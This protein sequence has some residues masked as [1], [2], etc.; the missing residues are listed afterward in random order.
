MLLQRDRGGAAFVA[1]GCSSIVFCATKAAQHIGHLLGALMQWHAER[2]RHAAEAQELLMRFLVM[3]IRKGFFPIRSMLSLPEVQRVMW[4]AQAC[5]RSGMDALTVAVVVFVDAAVRSP[6]YSK[7][8]VE[9]WMQRLC[10]LRDPI[11]VASALIN[12]WASAPKRFPSFWKGRSH[13]HLPASMRRWSPDAVVEVCQRIVKCTGCTH[14]GHC[15]LDTL[16][17]LPGVGS[18]LS[19][20]VLRN[21]APVFC[22][23]SVFSD[24]L[25]FGM[26]P[27]T[28]ALSLLDLKSVKA[29]LA[30]E[31]GQWC[32]AW[33]KDVLSA[34]LCESTKL[35]LHLGFLPSTNNIRK[36][37]ADARQQLN[38]A[39]LRQWLDMVDKWPRWQQLPA[40]EGVATATAM[41]TSIRAV[42]LDSVAAYA[43]AQ[44]NL[45]IQTE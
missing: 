40:A 23:D 1:K 38:S 16:Q 22:I 31:V 44:A 7:Q 42:S 17:R 18:Y 33:G 24:K 6:M 3:M 45:L 29:H 10:V 8:I 5:R 2:V 13:R 21:I 30:K 35:L 43:H 36:E 12:C 14:D 19:M 34:L 39:A 15:L 32:A 27:H 11:Q 28:A 4:V 20:A 37:P 9:H 41:G 26:S 25:I